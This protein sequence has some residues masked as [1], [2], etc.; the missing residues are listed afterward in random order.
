MVE[1]LVANENVVSSNLITRSIFKKSP[2]HQRRAFF[3]ARDEMRTKFER[4]TKR[5]AVPR[6]AAI[7]HIR[8]P[9]EDSCKSAQP[10]RSEG[11]LIIRQPNEVSAELE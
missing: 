7:P 1:H 2:T 10:E 4:T 6:I 5:S 9:E 11:N 8:N 3:V